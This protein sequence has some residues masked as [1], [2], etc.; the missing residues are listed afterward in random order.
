MRASQE[1]HTSRSTGERLFKRKH[2]EPWTN[3]RVSKIIHAYCAHLEN[4][5][6]PIEDQSKLPYSKEDIKIA[7]LIGIARPPEGDT[8]DLFKGLFLRLA[9]FQS[10]T[11][12]EVKAVAQFDNAISTGTSSLG[13]EEAASMIAGCGELYQK[14]SQRTAAETRALQMELSRAL[15]QSPGA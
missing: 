6:D 10:L 11:I 13:I 1:A 15:R 7:M 8:K 3:L 4:N 5:N 12:A 9:S 14:V 2:V